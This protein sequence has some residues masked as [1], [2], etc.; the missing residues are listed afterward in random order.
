M[1]TGTTYDGRGL[2]PFLGRT[3]PVEL[4]SALQEVEVTGSCVVMTCAMERHEP[5]LQDYYG[6]VCETVFQAPVPGRPAT[7]RADFWTPGTLR[8]RYS[9]GGGSPTRRSLHSAVRM[10]SVPWWSVARHPTSGSASS[11]T[12]TA[13]SS[14]RR[15]WS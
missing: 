5:A 10:R 4:V 11:S 6:T 2:A 8:L 9:P 7:V 1:S 13:S 14:G 12:R 3:V 15:P